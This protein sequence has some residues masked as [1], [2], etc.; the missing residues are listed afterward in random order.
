M[1]MRIINSHRAVK[2]QNQRPWPPPEYRRAFIQ[3]K[4]G[5]KYIFL[6][7][8]RKLPGRI[9]SGISSNQ[10]VMR[11][12]HQEIASLSSPAQASFSR[13]SPAFRSL[14]ENKGNPLGKHPLPS[15]DINYCRAV[16]LVFN[17]FLK[18]KITSRGKDNQKPQSQDIS[19]SQIK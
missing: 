5:R 8:G 14:K 19:K 13:E 15:A 7:P 1:K 17:I 10:A 16:F 12:L 2:A 9:H 4:G 6:H 18:D 11:V 3:L